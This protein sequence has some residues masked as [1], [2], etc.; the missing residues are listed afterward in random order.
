VGSPGVGASD[1]PAA[2]ICVYR[3]REKAIP[4]S[5]LG[6]HG[7]RETE[8]PSASLGDNGQRGTGNGKPLRFARG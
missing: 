2:S 8:S 4:A 7:Q 6:F 3:H 5:S 1:M